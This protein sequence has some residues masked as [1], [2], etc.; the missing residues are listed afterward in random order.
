MKPTIL[1]RER[2][3]SARN[4]PGRLAFT[5]VVS[6]GVIAGVS[7]CRDDATGLSSTAAVPAIT[8]I[9]PDTA[10]A[11]AQ[12]AIYVENLTSLSMATV[13]VLFDS[14]EVIPDSSSSRA[15]FCT[16]PPNAA[17][18]IIL[19][20]TDSTIYPGPYLFVAQ[21]LSIKELNPSTPFIGE[22]LRVTFYKLYS[23]EV[24][25]YTLDFNGF[26]VHPNG[27]NLSHI[28]L[29]SD[30][31]FVIVPSGATS[32]PLFVYTPGDTATYPFVEINRADYS[33]TAIVP[34]SVYVGTTFKIIG[35]G[36][37]F[38]E[39]PNYWH[40]VRLDQQAVP[41]R[42]TSD[43]CVVGILPFNAASNRI[44]LRVAPSITVVLG[45]ILTVLKE[46]ETLPYLGWNVAET[47]APDY[48]APW[49]I[50]NSHD[51][52]LISKVFP[53]FEW[54]N[55]RTL[56]FRHLQN[57]QLPSF[58]YYEDIYN[59]VWGYTD[60]VRTDQVLIRIQQWDTSDAILGMVV[61]PEIAPMSFWYNF[62]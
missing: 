14:V 51:S 49:S 15:L 22:A 60:T 27:V 13:R 47:I 12:I 10:K 37:K 39:Y 26:L 38:P 4:S 58:L 45:P 28:G 61:G 25:H 55:G 18:C 31:I 21:K 24:S 43:S 30:F 50:T 11:G 23:A 33:I 57:D 34:E 8:R 20:R 19:I 29:A 3:S 44:S 6:M 53:G 17:S 56:C 40:E 59:H 36:F 5:L 62:H 48:S 7:G 52:I 32:G 9:E 54:S 46:S 16:I 42:S 2:L 41:A 1:E 35:H